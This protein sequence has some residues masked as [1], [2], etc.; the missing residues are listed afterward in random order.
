MEKYYLISMGYTDLESLIFQAV[1]RAFTLNKLYTDKALK[2][3]N[4]AKKE[5]AKLNKEIAKLKNSS[6]G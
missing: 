4:E 3:L 1:N 6:N 2:D 5:I